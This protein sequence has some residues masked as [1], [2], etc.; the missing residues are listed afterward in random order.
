MSLV[1]SPWPD[2]RHRIVSPIF[3]GRLVRM[4]DAHGSLLC[5]PALKKACM[6]LE[7]RHSNDWLL[8]SGSHFTQERQ[9]VSPLLPASS[10]IRTCSGTR[11]SLLSTPLP[12]GLC[13]C[14]FTRRLHSPSP[15]RLCAAIT[16]QQGSPDTVFKGP[17]A[18]PTCSVPLLVFIF[19]Q[20]IYRRRL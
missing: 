19:L 4:P 1:S 3:V 8:C 18:H 13:T 2:C 5:L 17:Q 20:V 11:A 16:S 14:H 9:A 12:Q 15:F 6:L 10:P 7:Q